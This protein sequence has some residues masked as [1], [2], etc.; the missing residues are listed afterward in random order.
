MFWLVLSISLGLTTAASRTCY[1][2]IS[3][4]S[5]TGR[6][7]G[8]VSASNSAVQSDLSA[9]NAQR[10]C[11]QASADKNCVQASVIAAI[12]S[13][14]SNGG[15]G[16]NSGYGDGRKAWGIM[17]CD[18]AKSGLPCTSVPWNS[19]E[20]IE[21]MVSR[22]LVPDIKTIARRLSS[23]SPSQTLQGAVA[24][25]NFGTKNV[26]TWGGVD[27][28]TTQGDYSNDIIA[29]AKWLLANGWN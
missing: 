17:Q 22:K 10:S 25:Y 11:Y 1:G 2:D 24:A 23:W 16:L 20:H 27:V 21:M 5:P 28:G 15:K 13:R 3:Q 4:L 9:L 14:E 18:I 8:G 12:A 7:P 29:R 6:K 19:C 26:Q